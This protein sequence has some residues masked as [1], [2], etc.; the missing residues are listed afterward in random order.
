M[1]FS[2]K[3]MFEIVF[4]GPLISFDVMISHV[5]AYFSLLSLLR[6]SEPVRVICSQIAAD[7]A[8]RYKKKTNKQTNKQA[9]KQTI[10]Q[11]SN[12]QAQQTT[13]QAKPNIQTN[14]QTNRQTNK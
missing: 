7:C 13:K 2:F 12:T 8:K 14:T 9:N 6:G 3:T 11:T 5:L 10:K 4:R 1:L